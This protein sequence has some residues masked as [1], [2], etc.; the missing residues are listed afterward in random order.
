MHNK[1]IYII[2]HTSL[3]GGTEKR[4]SILWNYL[5]TKGY[6]DIFLVMNEVFF[7]ALI[8]T[9]NL[10]HLDINNKRLIVLKARRFRNMILPLIKIAI[11][12]GPGAVFHYPLTGIS[13]IHTLLRQKVIRSLTMNDI[14]L[15]NDSKIKYLH[16]Y[17][18][19]R[20]WKID[21]LNPSVIN[22]LKNTFIIG[23]L[24]NQ[25]LH[26]TKGNSIEIDVSD[27]IGQ[28][29]N[30]IV[31]LG[32]FTDEAGDLKNIL[33]YIN[34]IPEI[35]DFLVSQR[36]ENLKYFLLGYGPLEPV[37]KKTLNQQRY[38]NIPISCYFEPNPFS[39]LRYSKVFL[40]LQKFSNYP[41]RSLLE[42]LTAFN[43]PVITDIGESRL[44]ATDEFACF[45][46]PDFDVKT[47]SQAILDIL[48]LPDE[49][50]KYKA[51]IA[52][53]FIRDNFTIDSHMN[54]FLDLYYNRK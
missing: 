37:M 48:L 12:A 26:L 4:L 53:K 46:H 7:N 27:Q 50:F 17:Q 25:K 45:I 24:L 1:K 34:L 47:L 30:W 28:K 6:L 16:Y 23:S 22:K 36:I 18:L 44:M 40:S 33:K 52:R 8:Q 11:K 38:S 32:R 3:M 10:D 39:I 2:L 43:L 35:H 5:Q 19:L 29:Q 41:S 51:F 49:S 31:F 9:K 13:F 20:S 54:Y 15:L 42:A 21:V 14:S